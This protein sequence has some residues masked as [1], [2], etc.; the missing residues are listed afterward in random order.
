METPCKTEP[1]PEEP[2]HFHV[3]MGTFDLGQFMALCCAAQLWQRKKAPGR[4]PETKEKPKFEREEEAKG[5][6]R[7]E[8]RQSSTLRM[9]KQKGKEKKEKKWKQ[10]WQRKAK[11]K[12]EDARRAAT[13]ERWPAF[14]DLV[15]SK[16][17]PDSYLGIFANAS[18]S[19][20]TL[21]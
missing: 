8:K 14:K 15:E 20:L 13:A 11:E 9:Q 1:F 6:K 3:L 18:C 10:N 19:Q 2:L 5:M 7:G 4:S 12:Q 16:P 21:L 17:S